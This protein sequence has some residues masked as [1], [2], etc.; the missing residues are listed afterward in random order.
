MKH[1]DYESP[2]LSSIDVDEA[3]IV[4]ASGAV[5]DDYNETN[6]VWEGML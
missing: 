4:C 2:S 5:N 6:Y 1:L 3:E